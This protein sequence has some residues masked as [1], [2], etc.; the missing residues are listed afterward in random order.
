MID[1]VKVKKLKT[2][3]DERGY[4][5]EI[6]RC[7]DDQ[8]EKFGQVYLSSVYAGVVKGWHCHTRQTD[9]FTV[10]SGMAK[11]VLADLRDDSPTKGEVNEFFIGDQNRLLIQ[12]P[13]GVYHGIKGV[14]DK[15][16]LALNCPTEPYNHDDPDEKRFPYDT[17]QIDYDW[18]LKQG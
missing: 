12:I 7:D 5:F 13:P 17:D 8:F 2:I 10:I 18:G 16:A 1:G 6:L 9:N 4:L 14:G 3:A 15:T 11:M